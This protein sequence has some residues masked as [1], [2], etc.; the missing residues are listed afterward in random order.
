M[1]IRLPFVKTAIRKEPPPFVEAV[2]FGKK[3][4]SGCFVRMDRI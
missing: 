4:R 3:A 1:R 2:L